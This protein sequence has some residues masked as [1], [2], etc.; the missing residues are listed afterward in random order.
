[1]A[2]CN[3]CGSEIDDRAVI[4]PK[5]GIPRRKFK[6]DNGGFLWGLLG[7]LVPMAGLVIYL[8]WKDTKPKS[9][10]ATGIG[11]LIR[12]FASIFIGIIIGICY[13]SIFVGLYIIMLL[14]LYCIFV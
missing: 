9:A 4:C 8:L 10:K 1:M 6:P 14:L 13:A 2:F 11:A 7:F 3:H 5:C 12:V